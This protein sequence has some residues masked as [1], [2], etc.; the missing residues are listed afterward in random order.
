MKS[1]FKFDLWTLTSGITAF[2]TDVKTSFILIS[3]QNF[4]GLDGHYVLLVV[5]V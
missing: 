4:K 1:Y 5:Y 2:S 3:D